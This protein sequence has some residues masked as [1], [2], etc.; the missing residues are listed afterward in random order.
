MNNREKVKTRQS[1]PAPGFHHGSR[2]YVA[3]LPDVGLALVRVSSQW[4]ELP[5][6]A[7]MRN[8]PGLPKRHWE[9]QGGKRKR[10]GSIPKVSQ[11]GYI[12]LTTEG[13]LKPCEKTAR[14]KERDATLVPV[15]SERITVKR[16]PTTI[17]LRIDPKTGDVTGPP[18]VN[19]V[20][21]KM[22]RRPP[23]NL[24]RDNRET[25]GPVVVN[26]RIA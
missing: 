15:E 7:G 14:P 11:A 16:K 8:K 9:L 25:S 26:I 20:S 23:P 18:G 2:Y 12:P 1:R 4:G 3:I 17:Q 24:R 22:I 6:V 5:A 19:V 21:N 10:D 13:E